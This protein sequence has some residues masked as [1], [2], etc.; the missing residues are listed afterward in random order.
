MEALSALTPI[1]STHKSGL[2]VPAPAVIEEA[3]NDS[4]QKV[5]NQNGQ[6]GHLHVRHD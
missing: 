3:N 5:T 4:P 1:A 6:I 2:Q